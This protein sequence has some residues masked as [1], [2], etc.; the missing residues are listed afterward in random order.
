M[1][2]SHTSFIVE[3]NKTQTNTQPEIMAVFEYCLLNDLF[4][5][6]AS[7][8]DIPN[9]F[10]VCPVGSVEFVLKAMEKMG[11][12][13]TPPI[14]YPRRLDPFFHRPIERLSLSETLKLLERI[15]LFVKPAN[16]VKGMTGRVFNDAGDLR[17][18]LQNVPHIAQ[19]IVDVWVA[20]PRFFRTGMAHLH[21]S[22]KNCRNGTIRR[23]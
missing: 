1:I 21:L 11:A 3:K 9:L 17:K 10:P 22:G 19:K 4:Y 6:S 12:V 16:I 20:P 8:D 13:F 15:P 2:R 7:I 18:E 5:V 23:R 14:G